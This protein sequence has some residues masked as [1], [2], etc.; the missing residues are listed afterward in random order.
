[1]LRKPFIALFLLFSLVCVQAAVFEHSTKIYAVTNEGQGL[2]AEL[3]LRIEPGN[4]QIFSGIESLVGTSTQNAFKVAVDLAKNFVPSADQYNYYFSIDST[5][6]IV[7]GPSAGAATALLVVSMLQDKRIPGNVAMTGTISDSGAVGTVGGVFEKAQAAKNGGIKL[8][9]IPRGEARQITRTAQGIQSINLV[10][11][12]PREW[13]MKVVEVDSLDEALELSFSNIEN[14]DVNQQIEE[15]RFLFVPEPI[16]VHPQ[17][18]PLK[19]ITEKYL[20]K[21]EEALKK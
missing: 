21:A 8:F 12:A 11:Y 2:Q 6:S 7:D 3:N 15:S 14:I 20:Q 13:G 5:A 9:L 1:M 4:G 17:V 19:G 18:L 10:E 16:A